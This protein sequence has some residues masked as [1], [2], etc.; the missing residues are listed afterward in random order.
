MNVK[1]YQLTHLKIANLQIQN[2]SGLRQIIN[3]S[4]YKQLKLAELMLCFVVI[5]TT[6]Y[7]INQTWRTTFQFLQ[8]EE[9]ITMG[10]MFLYF[11]YIADWTI[12]TLF[13]KAIF[14]ECYDSIKFCLDAR[15]N[16][17][18][19][20]VTEEIVSLQKYYFYLLSTL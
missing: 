11:P 3:L 8:L 12:N 14:F 2:I 19:M 16:N 9:I 13:F 18:I 6:A 1:N 10:S 17:Q 4:A 20:D 7:V 15:K 5:A